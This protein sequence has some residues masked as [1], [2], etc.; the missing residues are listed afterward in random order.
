MFKQQGTEKGV[1]M[2]PPTFGAWLEH[3]KR[4]HCQASIWEQDL[5]LNRQVP[6]PTKLGWIKQAD[7]LMPELSKVAPAPSAVVELVR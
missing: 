3:V 4:A 5:V 2:L 7:H 6:D 1:D